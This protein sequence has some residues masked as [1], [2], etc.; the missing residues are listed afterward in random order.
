M[1]EK[2]IIEVMMNHDL[3]EKMMADTLYPNRMKWPSLNLIDYIDT[4]GTIGKSNS[5][6]NERFIKEIKEQN[7]TIDMIRGSD[8]FEFH[9]LK[10]EYDKFRN[11]NYKRMQRINS[12]D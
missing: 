5:G 1:S 8:G 11:D 6:M 3:K 4:V 2:S 12:I 10:E 9:V 7:I